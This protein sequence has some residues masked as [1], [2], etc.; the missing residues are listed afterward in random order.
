MLYQDLKSCLDSLGFV[1]LVNSYLKIMNFVDEVDDAISAPPSYGQ[2]D[3]SL[4]VDA[5]NPSDT[6]P[7]LDVFQARLHA[8]R[9][10]IKGQLLPTTQ[11]QAANAQ[12]K[13]AM[14]IQIV[15][16]CDAKPAFVANTHFYT[17]YSR[18]EDLKL[19]IGELLSNSKEIAFSYFKDEQCFKCKLLNRSNV[20]E[21]N[22][23]VYWDDKMKD[24][25][26]EVRRVYGDGVFIFGADIFAELVSGITREPLREMSSGK[27]RRMDFTVPEDMLMELQLTLEQFIEGLR[28]VLTMANDQYY[29]TRIEAVK[30]LC[31]LP[32]S[33]GNG[34]D[35]QFLLDETVVNEI[36]PV[37]QKLL[38]DPFEDIQEFAVV[39]VEL[40]S[41]MP[42]YA[43]RFLAD[44]AVVS[45]LVAAIKSLKE[46]EF[47]LHAH[48]M[49]K[50]LNTLNAL[51]AVNKV[52]LRQRLS[53]SSRPTIEKWMRVAET[54]TMDPIAKTMALA[55]SAFYSSS[56]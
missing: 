35:D 40:F 21:L 1:L 29:E 50:A 33:N 31:E 48:M 36:T 5:I 28:P 44:S 4:V 32:G 34:R 38:K 26:V 54:L 2:G 53:E 24:H 51:G 56:V 37:L 20:R 13:G 14:D 45:S 46:E 3:D 27:L 15:S 49:R 42:A 7:N 16:P 19:V 30:M 47:Y 9:E 8:P 43:N 11:Q 22:V 12:K 23:N 52:L 55:V 39:A 17:K 25:L 6:D 18:Y 41:A 10:N